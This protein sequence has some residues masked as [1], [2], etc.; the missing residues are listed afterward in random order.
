[1][2]QITYVNALLDAYGT[3]L[4]EKQQE[5]MACYYEEDLSF[6]EI[7]E[8][9]AISKAAVSDMIK[10]CESILNH[11]ESHLHLVEKNK[12]RKDLYDSIKT[13]GN[14]QVNEWIEELEQLDQR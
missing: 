1:M 6:S 13:L 7:A 9:Y 11:Y 2:K 12:L 8:N 10:R 3:L 4:T 5:M 14:E